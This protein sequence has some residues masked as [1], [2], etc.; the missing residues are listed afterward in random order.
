MWTRRIIS[1]LV[2]AL[3]VV[4]LVFC[5]GKLPPV[6]PTGTITIEAQTLPITKTIAWTAPPGIIDSYTVR[7]DGTVVGSPTGT[8]QSVTFTTLGLHAVTVTASNTWGTSPPGTLNVN[9]APPAAPSN[10][11]LQ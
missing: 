3:S 5:A 7:L 10:L 9:V 2:L 11:T 1:R 4:A 8:T 6:F